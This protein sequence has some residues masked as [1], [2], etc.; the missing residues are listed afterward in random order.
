MI[1]GG[2]ATYM[3]ETFALLFLSQFVAARGEQPRTNRP[4]K[5]QILKDRCNSLTEGNNTICLKHGGHRVTT[6]KIILFSVQ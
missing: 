1:S 2:T 6:W 5:S 3:L 4:F